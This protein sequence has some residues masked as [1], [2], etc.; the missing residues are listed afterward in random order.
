MNLWVLILT[1]ADL[2]WDFLKETTR[3]CLKSSLL[4]FRNW[5][6]NHLKRKT[7]IFTLKISQQGDR[8]QVL[9]FNRRSVYV[10]YGKSCSLIRGI[11]QKFF[12][13]MWHMAKVVYLYKAY[14]K[15]C[16][17]LCG[18]WQ[19]LFTYMWHKAKV[20]LMTNKSIQMF[21]KSS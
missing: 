16:S 18:I 8:C 6:V 7:D 2:S 20:V 13:Y 14:S 11:W 19:K 1:P 9:C 15:S 21:H 10:A 5:F 3:N 4:Y 17:L 12:T